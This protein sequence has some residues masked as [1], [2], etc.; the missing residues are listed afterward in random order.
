MIPSKSLLTLLD[1]L[2]RKIEIVKLMMEK[3]SNPKEYLCRA[4]SESSDPALRNKAVKV[5]GWK[6]RGRKQRLTQHCLAP[7][8]TESEDLRD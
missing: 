6:C 5:G 8:M 3:H 7:I 1:Y 4:P 2:D